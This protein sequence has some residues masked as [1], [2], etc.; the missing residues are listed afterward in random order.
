M[1]LRID[2]GLFRYDFIDH[3]AI[4][5]V[6]VDADVKE[7][8]KRYLKIARHLHPDSSAITTETEKKLAGELLSKLVNPAYETLSAERTRSE[9]II[10]LSQMGKRLVQESASIELT[11]DLG[12]QLAS[13]PNVD[14]LYK[15]AIAKIAETQYNSLKEVI[16]IISQI[17]EL[18]LVYLMRTAGKT[19]AASTA[20]P[21]VNS[22]PNQSK[23]AAPPPQPEPAKEDSSIEQYLRRAQTL[24]DKNQF[25]P[26]EVELK[27]ALKIAP[28]SSRC[29]SL[30]AFVYLKQNKLKM[31][32]I[33]FDNTLKLDPQDQT[34]LAW[35]PKI[36]KA[37]GQ[38]T[39]SSNANTSTTTSNKQ[40]EKSGGGLFGG[41]FGGKKK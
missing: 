15:S 24:I 5:C 32:K 25:A 40:P 12:K 19:F 2:R 17:S 22:T 20:K 13:A 4:L 28:K 3:H 30:L 36:D 8:R 27:D 33:H 18:N 11:T 6:A 7:I 37:L 26:A 35:K 41:L 9:Y 14:L 23:E 39:S 31:A 1:S 38:Q 10:V 29:H 16:T 21:L 34:A